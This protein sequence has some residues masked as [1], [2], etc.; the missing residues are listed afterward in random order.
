MTTTN[1]GP[2]DAAYNR[3]LDAGR[4]EQR[5]Q[6]HDDHFQQINGSIDAMTRA[7]QSLTE[8]VRAKAAVFSANATSDR[9]DAGEREK[10]AITVAAALVERASTVEAAKS[11]RWMTWQRWF[12]VAGAIVLIVNFSLGLYLAFDR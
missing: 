6:G 3:G 4:I 1:S 12:A 10:I 9:R 5:L 7:L 8:E 2:E 11:N